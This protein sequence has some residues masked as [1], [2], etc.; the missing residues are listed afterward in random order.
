MTL[1]KNQPRTGHLTEDSP[2]V[3]KRTGRPDGFGPGPQRLHGHKQEGGD[4]ATGPNDT[5]GARPFRRTP[6]NRGEDLAREPLPEVSR[7][8]SV[9]EV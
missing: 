7:A 9:R 2:N 8:D 5:K 6:S 4:L 1:K 3:E